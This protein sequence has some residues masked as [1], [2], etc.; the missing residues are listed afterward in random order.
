[1]KKIKLIFGLLAFMLVAI[2]TKAQTAA[3]ATS[4]YFVGKWAV[5]VIG[6]PQGDSKLNLVLERKD[7]KLTGTVRD[8]TDKELSKITS[9]EEKDKTINAAFNIQSYDVTLLLEPVDDDHIK[10]N[11]MGMFDAKGVRLKENH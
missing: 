3:T 4:D 10:G 1:M 7:G 2:S 8:T 5:T 6:T 11:L 9:I